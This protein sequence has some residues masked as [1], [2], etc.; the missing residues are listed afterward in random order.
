[1]KKKKTLT[2]VTPNFKSF[3]KIIIPYFQRAVDIGSQI[4]DMKEVVKKIA[5]PE[6]IQQSDNT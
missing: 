6:S 4:F 2:K 1:M 5:E 3:P